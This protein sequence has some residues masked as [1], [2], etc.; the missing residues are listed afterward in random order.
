M[1]KNNMLI[2]TMS[3][4]LAVATLFSIMTVSASAASWRTG[5]SL[6]ITETPAILRY[7]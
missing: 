2:K 5:I 6:Q 1:T 3:L 4:I 7:A